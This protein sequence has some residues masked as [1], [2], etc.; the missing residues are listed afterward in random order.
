VTVLVEGETGTGKELIARAIHE[1]SPRANGPFV[2][3]DAASVPR[4]LLESMLFGHERGAFTGASDRRIG[5]MEEANGGTLVLDELGELPLALQPRLL[6]ALESRTVLPVGANEP[7]SV[8]VRVVAATNRDLAA[9]VNAGTFRDDLYYRLAVVRVVVAA[10]RDRTDDVRPLV[11]H[12]VET[13]LGEEAAAALLSRVSDDNWRELESYRWPGN[14]RELRNMVQRTL[15]LG[16]G[17]A[18]VRFD[19]TLDAVHRPAA[20][21]RRGAAAAPSSRAP[22]DLERPFSEQKR[23]IVESFESQYLL[24]MLERHDGNISR[25]AAD[26]HMDRMYFKRLLKKYRD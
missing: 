22:V 21:P 5:L 18:T 25:A 11:S 26:S 2:V 13:S 4:D 14:V 6:R 24:G 12:L 1:A 20:A 3:F 15:A 10:L 8:D 19:P 9:E 16:A 23:A 7:R 17:D